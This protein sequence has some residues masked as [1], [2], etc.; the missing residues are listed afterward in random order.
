MKI[1]VLNYLSISLFICLFISTTANA[2][3]PLEIQKGVLQKNFGKQLFLYE[4]TAN[5]LNI[6][7]AINESRFQK[8]ATVVPN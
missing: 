1:S 7:T 4:D 8:A 6:E 3:S 5:S 2:Q